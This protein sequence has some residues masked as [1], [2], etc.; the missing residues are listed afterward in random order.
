[1]TESEKKSS[2]LA[3]RYMLDKAKALGLETIWDHY[4]AMLPQCGFGELGVCCR[5]CL[6]GPCRIDPFG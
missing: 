1:M 2:D 3:S 6:E 4:E 5:M